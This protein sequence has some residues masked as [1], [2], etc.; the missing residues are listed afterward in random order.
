MEL[1]PNLSPV[2]GPSVW[3]R[4]EFSGKPA[5]IAPR[6]LLGAAGVGLLLAAAAQRRGPRVLI[7][8]GGASLIAYA[9]ASGSLES[10]RDWGRCRLDEWRRN[11]VV[12][13]ASEASF[14]A[15]DSPAWTGAV[16]SGAP[17]VPAERC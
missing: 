3:S 5:S 8:C 13:E 14:P 11:D 4:V 9:A 17:Q 16:G 6:L 15:S 1:N 10:W 7:A 2:R 12:D